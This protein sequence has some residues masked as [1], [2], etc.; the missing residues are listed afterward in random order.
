M[1]ISKDNETA[2]ERERSHILEVLNNIW[3]KLIIIRI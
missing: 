1:R 2:A 3:T